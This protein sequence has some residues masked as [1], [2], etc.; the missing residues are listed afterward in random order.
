ML[1]LLFILI[2]AS[3]CVYKKQTTISAI[4]LEQ[5]T[6]FIGSNLSTIFYIILFSALTLGFFFMMIKEYTGLISIA[7]PEFNAE[8]DIYYE[9]NSKGLWIVWIILGIQFL[10]GLS[11]LKESCNLFIM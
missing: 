5:G 10:W 4:F 6:N 3:V 9:V 1:A 7:A 2:L 8:K 11:F